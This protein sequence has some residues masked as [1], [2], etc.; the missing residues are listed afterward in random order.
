MFVKHK[1]NNALLTIFPEKLIYQ[2]FSNSC[3]CNEHSGDT[4]TMTVNQKE[5]LVVKDYWGYL[6]E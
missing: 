6:L 2:F 1:T 5:A 3:N 4:N